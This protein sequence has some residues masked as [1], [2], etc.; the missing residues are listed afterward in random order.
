MKICAC[1]ETATRSSCDDGHR[2][3][4]LLLPTKEQ[5]KNK[6]QSQY[7]KYV[8]GELQCTAKQ[9]AAIKNNYKSWR[10]IDRLL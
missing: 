4:I 9:G 10:K 7:K 6:L 1:F 2:N 3:S 5:V 8:S